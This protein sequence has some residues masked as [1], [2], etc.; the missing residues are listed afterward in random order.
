[1][2]VQQGV[3]CGHTQFEDGNTGTTGVGGDLVTV[4]PSRSIPVPET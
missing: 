1:M 2:T 3:H 4:A